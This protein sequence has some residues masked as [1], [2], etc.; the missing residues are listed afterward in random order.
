MTAV[1]E[2]FKEAMGRLASGVSVVTTE[3]DGR[4][5]GLTVSA[6]CSI[7]MAPPLI[8][9]SLAT[10]TVSARA[11]LEQGKFGVSILAEDQL[12]VGRAGSKAGAPKFFDE[13]V[14]QHEFSVYGVENALAQICCTVYQSVVA[15]DHTIFLG[16]VESV[17]L[18]EFRQPL[19]YFNRS[20][21]ELGRAL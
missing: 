10:N 8:L 19:L 9:V 5:W 6:C 13:Y 3:V 20:F 11:I 16:N 7:S 15:G 12:D 18:G 14:E 1:M 21:R 2:S 17:K 4:P